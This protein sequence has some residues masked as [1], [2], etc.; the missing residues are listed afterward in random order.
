MSFVSSYESVVYSEP[1]SLGDL[2]QDVAQKFQLRAQRERIRLHLQCRPASTWVHGDIGMIQRVLEILIEHAL[3]HTHRWAGQPGARHCK[4]DTRTARQYHPRREHGR[5]RH[6]VLLL[7]TSAFRVA[8][9]HR[10]WS[11]RAWPRIA[12]RVIYGLRH[13]AT[14]TLPVT[15]S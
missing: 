1:F 8:D 5:E 3:S 2:M 15:E 13:I 10:A 11:L 7:H 4:A 6:C 12:L 9:W 14:A